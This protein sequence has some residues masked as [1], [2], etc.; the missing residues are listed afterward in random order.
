MKAI[1]IAVVIVAAGTL[2]ACTTS[3]KTASGAGIGAAVGALASNS[4]GGAVAGAVIGGV[5][6]YLFQ[7]ADGRCQY[8]N[9]KGQVYTRRC[10]WR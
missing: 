5:G 6:T 3:E 4:V 10:H 8:R 2:A 7:T 1:K 9:S